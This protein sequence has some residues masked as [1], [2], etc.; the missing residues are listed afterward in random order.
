VRTDVT[1]CDATFF[2]TDD[3]APSLMASPSFSHH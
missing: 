2:P 1:K 3:I